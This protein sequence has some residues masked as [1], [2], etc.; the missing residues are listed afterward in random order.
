MKLPDQTSVEG[1]IKYDF[2]FK[3][4][5]QPAPMSTL[6]A[7]D[8]QPKWIT[9]N[10]PNNLIQNTSLQNPTTPFEYTLYNFDER[11]GQL[12]KKAAQRI[13][14]HQETETSLFP[15]TEPSSLCPVTPYKEAQTTDSSETEEEE[16]TI[17]AQLLHQRR[18]QKL[19]RKRINKLLLRLAQLE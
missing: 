13:T 10:N 12:T 8:K 15:I 2:Y 1:H 19:L 17:E 9:P 5:G 11:R 7:P 14:K 4:G 16:T 3:V 18:E 6:T